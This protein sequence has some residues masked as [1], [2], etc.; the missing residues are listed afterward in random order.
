MIKDKVLK[1]GVIG[2]SNKGKSFVL[3]KIS[4]IALP[5]G[6][7]IKTE[8]LSI[9]Y[10]ELE[11][12]KDRKIVL[13]DSA[14]LETPVLKENKV[15]LIPPNPNSINYNNNNKNTYYDLFKEKSREKM[16]T[17]LFL[18]NYITYN[19]DI[20]IVVVGLLTYSEQKLL[21]K[22]KY[23]IR[24]AKLN[25]TLYVIHNLMTYTTKQ[26]VEDYINITLKKCATFELEEQIKINLETTRENGVCFYEKNCYPNVF[27]LIFANDYSEAGKYY[28]EY[29]LKYLIDIFK[30]NTD[31]EGFDIIKTI[32]ERFKDTSKEIFEKVEG[33]IIFDESNKDIIKLKTPKEIVL[34]K[35]FIDEIGFP[36]IKPNNF[37]PT[38]NYYKEIIKLYLKLKHLEIVIWNQILNIMGNL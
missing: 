26:Q 32:K 21:N 34:K 12:Y 29:T 4:K 22:I 24:R 15:Y 13:L 9:K 14:G 1:I 30:T 25:K 35:C 36:L 11:V 16:I 6:T 18:Q 8:G 28:N 33:E 37:E 27:H 31:L 19:S 5:S 38:Y 2:N 23:N 3:S 17:E 10:P 7:S 20:L